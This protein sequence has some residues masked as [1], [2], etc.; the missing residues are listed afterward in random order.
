MIALIKE[1]TSKILKEPKLAIGAALFVFAIFEFM[2][3]FRK[4]VFSILMSR[5]W[6]LFF[7]VFLAIT[8]YK[9]CKIVI[10]DIRS[11]NYV[12]LMMVFGVGLILFWGVGNV[13]KRQ[14]EYEFAWQYGGTMRAFFETDDWNFTGKNYGLYSQRQFYPV[15]LLGF[16]FGNSMFTLTFMFDLLYFLGFVLAYGGV[17]TLV[18]EKK[19]IAAI[20]IALSFCSPI[21]VENIHLG[22]QGVLPVIYTLL[23]MGYFFSLNDEPGLSLPNLFGACFMALSLAS[24]YR[25][26]TPIFALFI[27]SLV[28]MLFK[29]KEKNDRFA[30]ASVLAWSVATF[31]VSNLSNMGSE[32]WTI[33][34]IKD[35]FI[36]IMF[37]ADPYGLFRFLNIPIWLVSLFLIAK[38]RKILDIGIVGFVF[39]LVFFGMIFK[40]NSRLIDTNIRFI[41]IVPLLSVWLV[42]SLY[43]K[44]KKH[45]LAND[46]Y[47][48]IA[49]VLVL[50][51]GIYNIITPIGSIAIAGIDTVGDGER[52]KIA[53]FIIYDGAKQTREQLNSNDG[54]VMVA[55]SQAGAWGRNTQPVESGARN[56]VWNNKFDVEYIYDYYDMNEAQKEKFQSLNNSSYV[57]YVKE[58]SH[59]PAFVAQK[60]GIEGIG[61]GIGEGI[62]E[63]IG[64]GGG[65]EGPKA[66]PFL[67]GPEIKKLNL[68]PCKPME[69]ILG[70]IERN[71]NKVTLNKLAQILFDYSNEEYGDDAAGLGKSTPNFHALSWGIASGIIT[72]LSKTNQNISLADAIVIMDR[73]LYYKSI[74]L[75]YYDIDAIDAAIGLDGESKNTSVERLARLNLLDPE[76]LMPE[77]LG[78]E[79]DYADLCDL[80]VKL[81]EAIQLFRTL[82]FEEI[83]LNTGNGTH[84]ILR[85]VNNPRANNNL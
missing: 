76:Q 79:I 38:H 51:I 5:V 17:K 4:G 6:V 14:F 52:N 63:G 65:P 22:D 64:I 11:K 49:F 7:V 48:I 46:K 43:H 57:Q 42:L 84:R 55:S 74:N 24:T 31:I 13:L 37:T 20:P 33:A 12:P 83:M 70:S 27:V 25:A 77:Q 45:I 8:V 73:F 35:Y 30:L 44:Y 50:T 61:A 66:L 59:I 1:Y 18:K 56:M 28:Y 16:L 9:A 32:L 2:A 54:L 78:K 10:D 41:A 81:D 67:D 72:D 21:L 15:A 3:Q 19:W 36:Q 71:E 58:S 40:G 62:G 29:Y 39:G 75:V 85:L 80:F 47:P 34:E 69:N 53:Y 68:T 60:L 26:A 23:A 82:P